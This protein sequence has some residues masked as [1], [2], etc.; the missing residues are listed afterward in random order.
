MCAAVR[1]TVYHG[2]ID[3]LRRVHPA[4]CRHQLAQGPVDSERAHV[5]KTPAPPSPGTLFG[6]ATEPERANVDWGLALAI[7]R[8]RSARLPLCSTKPDT[9]A[10]GRRTG[11]GLAQNRC[12]MGVRS[13]GAGFGVTED[14]GR[15]IYE[16]DWALL[17]VSHL[18]SAFVDGRWCT[19]ERR[20]IGSND[21][22]LVKTEAMWKRWAS[23]PGRN[24]D[25][26]RVRSVSVCNCGGWYVSGTPRPTRL[27]MRQGQRQS[28]G[29]R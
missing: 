14:S 19:G 17:A 20:R 12:S 15:R 29:A 10:V 18:P 11:T 28:E 9:R 3:L 23:S 2:A 13:S 16:D 24:L 22:Q 8:A 1:G 26:L 6:S 21:R 7:Y 27:R 5:R 4:P 25:G